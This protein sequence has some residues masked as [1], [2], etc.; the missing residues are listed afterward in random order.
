[1]V[2]TRAMV[3]IVTLVSGDGGPPDDDAFADLALRWQRRYN[4]SPR[5]ERHFEPVKIEQ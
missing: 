4:R 1:M 3:P 2:G 5:L